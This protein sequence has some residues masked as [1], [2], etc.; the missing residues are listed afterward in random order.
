MTSPR[1]LIVYG[2]SYGQTAKI[3]H[4]MEAVL[5]SLGATVTVAEAGRD[6]RRS[7]L[8][9]HDAVIVGASVLYGHHQR[10]V[11]DFVRAHRDAL[12]R[13]PN[14]FFSVSGSA[15][16]ATPAAQAQARQAVDAFARDTGWTPDATATFGG[17]M[18]YTHYNPLMRWV[19]RRISASH[20]APTDTSRD[21]EMTDW[22]AV[23]RF[24]RTFAERLV[25]ASVGQ[26]AGSAA[27]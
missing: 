6:A 22:G 20:G 2:T 23:E 24:A 4:R 7:P 16:T 26:P 12:G 10:T 5:A 8:A 13:L 18:A 25:P 3:A 21:Y 17:A 9:D 14:A 1:I 27:P 15:A 11:R 19:M